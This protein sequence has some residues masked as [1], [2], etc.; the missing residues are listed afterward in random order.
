[1]QFKGLG[2]P[3]KHFAGQNRRLY[4]QTHCLLPLWSLSEC[5]QNLKIV[6]Q[7]RPSVFEFNL[8]RTVI[9]LRKNFRVCKP[10]QAVWVVP[11]HNFWIRFFKFRFKNTCWASPKPNVQHKNCAGCASSRMLNNR[12]SKHKNCSSKSLDISNDI[13]RNRNYWFRFYGKNRNY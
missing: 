13:A 5:F 12:I 9:F 3:N 11:T 1:M 2:F 4:R 10:Q 8:K 7:D 6:L